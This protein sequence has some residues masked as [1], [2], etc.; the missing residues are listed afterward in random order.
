MTESLAYC[1]FGSDRRRCRAVSQRRLTLDGSSPV[2]ADNSSN[3]APDSL[4][5]TIN[6]SFAIMARELVPGPMRSVNGILKTASIA[7]MRPFVHNGVLSS[8]RPFTDL[9]DKVPG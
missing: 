5:I 3:V 8:D 4:P 1:I 7:V 9:W 2:I 6:T